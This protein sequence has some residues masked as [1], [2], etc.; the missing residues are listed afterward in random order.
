MWL[1]LCLILLFLVIGTTSVF[2]DIRMDDP[3]K[4]DLQQILSSP[5]VIIENYQLSK[6]DLAI[7]YQIREYKPAWNFEGDNNKIVFTDFINSLEQLIIYHGLDLNDYPLPLLRTLIA[8]PEPTS[9][10]KLELLTTDTLLQL[11]HD[12]HGDTL[13]LDDLYPGWDFHRRD[14]DLP[15]ALATAIDTNTTTD[16]INGLAPQN[17]SYRQLAILLKDYRDIASHNGWSKIDTGPTLRLNDHDKRVTQ[18]RHRLLDEHFDLAPL[19]NQSEDSLY[20]VDLKKAVVLYQQR[21]GLEPDGSLGLKTLID[22][23]IPVETRIDQI[24]ANMER[25]RHMPENWPSDRYVLVNIASATV[26]IYIDNKAVYNGPVIVGRVDRKTPFIQSSIK[27]MIINPFWH[28]PTKIIREDILPKLRQ[29]PHYLEKMGFVV[30]NDGDN[31]SD[32]TVDWKS[33]QE[34][35]FDFHLRQSPGS[36]NSLGRLKFDF[37]NNFAVYMHGTPH[38]ELF[39]K[40]ER[41]LSSGC[42]RLREPEQVAVILL[43]PNNSDWSLQHISEAIA[44]NKTRWIGFSKP[45]PVYFVYWTVFIDENNEINF[46]RDIYDYDR[47]LIE[48]MTAKPQDVPQTNHL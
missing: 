23:N 33:I 39:K 20:N 24:R 18:L 38:Q 12:L 13:N 32:S 46:R 17:Q 40:Y 3:E 30:S 28:V 35:E 44:S 9:Q 42:V 19:A 47:F 4:K 2:A 34:N 31:T 14:I 45:I 8:T 26:N 21:H 48:N 15:K 7:F 41:N 11:A 37:N 5:Q 25:W 6:D 36:L 22:L 16:F 43:A 1:K 27:S 10:V 29:D